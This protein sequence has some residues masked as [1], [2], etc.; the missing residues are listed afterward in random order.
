MFKIAHRGNLNGPQPAL[1]NSVE[2]IEAAFS[3]GF[4][5]EIDVWVNHDSQIFLGHDEPTYPITFDWIS[6]NSNKLWLHCKNELALLFF[7]SLDLG[8]NFFWHENDAFTRTSQGYIWAFPAT[9]PIS[10]TICVLPE[11]LDVDWLQ[12]DYSKVKGVCTDYIELLNK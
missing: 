11:R 4:D 9:R 1:E 5:C 2:Y 7:D 6:K 8:N 10:G 3:S 12:R